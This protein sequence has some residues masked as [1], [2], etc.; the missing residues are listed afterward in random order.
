MLSYLNGIRP[1]TR[2]AASSQ[3]PSQYQ[4]DINGNKYEGTA[5]GGKRHLNS[6]SRAHTAFEDLSSRPTTADPPSLPPIPRIASHYGALDAPT[7][8]SENHER[9]FQGEEIRDNYDM[10]SKEAHSRSV[11]RPTKQDVSSRHRE[12]VPEFSSSLPMISQTVQHQWSSATPVSHPGIQTREAP[13]YDE[14]ETHLVASRRTSE[15][16][17]GHTQF[18]QNYLPPA[19]TQSQV[20]SNAMTTQLRHGRPRLNLLNPMSILSRRRSAQTMVQVNES[21][22]SATRHMSSTGSRL[23]DDYDPRIRGKVVHDFSAPR[24]R[25]YVDSRERGWAERRPRPFGH[26]GDSEYGNSAEKSDVHEKSLSQPS[27]CMLPGESVLHTDKQHTPI[28]KEQ[29]GEEMEPWRFDIDDRRNQHTTGLLLRMTE[30]E[31]HDRNVP[32]PPFARSFPS[33]VARNLHMQDTSFLTPK[34]TPPLTTLDIGV[35]SSTLSTEDPKITPTLTPP[36][37]RSRATSTTD[38]SHQT[39]GLPKHFKS[40]ASRFSFDLA[41]VG[42]STQ[43]KLLEERHRQKNAPRRHGSMSSRVSASMNTVGGL[44]EE[45]GEDEFMVEDD[46]YD[47]LL[48]ERIPG[49]NA[50]ADD[51]MSNKFDAIS[52]AAMVGLPQHTYTPNEAA[53]RL[54]EDFTH[55]PNLDT[56]R[57]LGIPDGKQDRLSVQDN[58]LAASSVSDDHTAGDLAASQH[59]LEHIHESSIQRPQ[60]RVYEDDLYFDDGMIDQFENWDSTTF[61]ESVFDDDTSRIYGMP[62]RDLKPLPNI[63]ESSSAETSQQST[64][65]ISAESGSKA[66]HALVNVDPETTT[67]LVVLANTLPVRT[68][69]LINKAASAPSFDQSIGLTSD[70]LAAYHSALASAAEAAARDGRFDRKLSLDEGEQEVQ[71]YSSVP[72]PHVSFDEQKMRQARAIPEAFVVEDDANDFEF[73]DEQEDDAIIS[74]ANAEALENDEEGFYGREFGFFAH[75]SG[76][77]EAQYANGGYFGPA[78]IDGLKRS[79]S[80]KANFQEPSLT[81]ITER[82]EWSQRNSMVSLPMQGLYSPSLPTPGLAQLADAMQYEDDDMSLSALLKLRRGAF[83]GS[84]TSLVSSGSHKTGS[85][86]SYL[87]PTPGAALSSALSGSHLVSSGYS[88][89]GKDEMASGPDLHNGSLTLTLQTQGLMI[90]QPGS[91]QDRSSGSDSS[92]RRRNAVKGPGHSRS[93]SGTESVSYVKELDEE[94]AGRWVLEKRWMAEGGQIEILGRQVVEGGRI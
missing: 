23:P 59:S 91:L 29:F 92:P 44:G 39:A 62:L 15:V 53:I 86:Q 43:E 30:E 46:E 12:V 71:D 40:N 6:S 17:D 78:G 10:S 93:S 38:P 8:S 42:S 5:P 28:F 73:D 14:P 81:P 27:A 13:L 84:N 47:G 18:S 48:E 89:V 79:H 75:A 9:R 83:G 74:A 87:P 37:S 50:D 85:P 4:P 58:Q 35:A 69:S 32:L 7:T 77:G 26:S 80:G 1:S 2:R 63:I 21:S 61:D 22:Y 72:K 68:K 90:A 66:Y 88:L 51:D 64:R 60:K 31:P 34:K 52:R 25:P 19:S 49:V 20:P 33:D 36:K 56:P 65:P 41:G 57:A 16:V 24:S 76:S 55:H 11:T 54:Y 45:D 94:G 67:N 70:N 3:A 82:S